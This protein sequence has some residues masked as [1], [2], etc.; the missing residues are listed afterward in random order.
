M[1]SN[2]SPVFAAWAAHNGRSYTAEDFQGR[3]AIFTANVAR[4]ISRLG[5]SEGV[6][7]V[8]GLADISTEEFKATYLGHVAR[9]VV[10]ELG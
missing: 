7:D 8:N 2:P 9:N 1:Q 4:Q 3:L 10:T 6:T 5:L